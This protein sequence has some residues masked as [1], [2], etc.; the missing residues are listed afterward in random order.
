MAV[1]VKGYETK[2]KFIL[3]T[4]Q[5]LLENHASD[6]TVRSLANENGCSAPAL[7]RHFASLEYLIVVSSIK[8]LDEYLVEFGKLL[9]NNE[10][11]MKIY[12]DGWKL[13]N[14]YAFERPD[15]YYRLFWGEYNNEFANA[16][17]EYFELFPFS[18]SEKYPAYYYSMLFSD[19]IQERDFL[20]LHRAVSRKLL[21]EEE[22]LYFSKTNPLIVKGMLIDCMTLGVEERKLAEA[23]CNSLLE[24]NLERIIIGYPQL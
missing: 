8:F 21:T 12:I 14:R 15:I 22:A 7:Y 19:N 24:K 16:M 18:G 4:Y 23:E 20:I 9:D 17:Q 3:S 13:F 2:R 1:Y 10:N 6:L 5:K 11:L